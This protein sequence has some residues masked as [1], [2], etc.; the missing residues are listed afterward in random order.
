MCRKGSES[1]TKAILSVKKIT[2]CGGVCNLALVD[3]TT[4]LTLYSMSTVASFQV[5]QTKVKLQLF[6]TERANTALAGPLIDKT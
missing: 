1:K 4:F 5:V 2:T 3:K 6:H